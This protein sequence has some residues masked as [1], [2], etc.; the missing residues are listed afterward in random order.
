MANPSH[1]TAAE[2]FWQGIRLTAGIGFMIGLLSYTGSAKWAVA[3]MA[4]FGS[5][6]FSRAAYDLRLFNAPFSVGKPIKTIFVLALIWGGMGLLLCEVWPHS[7]PTA[8]N[9]PPVIDVQEPTLDEQ[10]KSGDYFPLLQDTPRPYETHSYGSSEGNLR[11]RVI[12]VAEKIE[13]YSKDH[14]KPFGPP[15]AVSNWARAGSDDFRANILLPLVDVHDEM[16]WFHYRDELLDTLLE[17]ESYK[18]QINES[19]GMTAN[20]F[21]LNSMGPRHKVIASPGDLDK[22]AE[23]LRMLAGQMKNP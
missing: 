14:P 18:E 7:F 15:D 8:H 9:E 20:L 11:E 22:I 3:L 4:V 2:W 17:T 21:D 5:L 6:C 12:N 10:K 16:K 23:R 13:A 19:G 1:Q